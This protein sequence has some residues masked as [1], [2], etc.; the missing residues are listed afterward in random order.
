[1]TTHP[2]PAVRWALSTAK[3]LM[4]SSISRGSFGC[5]H[6]QGA[7]SIGRVWWHLGQRPQ[8]LQYGSLQSRHSSPDSAEKWRLPHS[9]HRPHAGHVPLA[10]SKTAS[11]PGQWTQGS[12]SI[13]SDSSV[14][15]PEFRQTFRHLSHS[16]SIDSSWH[17]RGPFNGQTVTSSQLHR[18][19]AHIP[20]WRSAFGG[21]SMEG[22]GFVEVRDPVSFRAGNGDPRGRGR[23]GDTSPKLMLLD[24]HLCE[25]VAHECLAIFRTGPD[26]WWL[27]RRGAGG[28]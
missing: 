28:C 7:I 24:G 1:M 26:C 8:H 5:P 14:R 19:S 2:Q 21:G 23:R 9:G 16:S 18:G 10:G 22:F 11:Q 12:S 3:R 13:R 17:Q 20:E 25:I 15:M 27:A 6:S 4:S